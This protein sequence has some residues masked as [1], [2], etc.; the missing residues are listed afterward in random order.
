MLLGVFGMA[1]RLVGYAAGRFGA[2][3][4][5]GVGDEEKDDG[6]MRAG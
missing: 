3:C 6:E 5:I 4:W 1:S 2:G